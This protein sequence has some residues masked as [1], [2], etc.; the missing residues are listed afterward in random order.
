MRKTHLLGGCGRP[1]ASLGTAITCQQCARHFKVR[2]LADGR[3]NL[4]TKERKRQG[5]GPTTQR[6]VYVGASQYS[7]TVKAAD[8]A[9]RV[10]ESK[11]LRRKRIEDLLGQYGK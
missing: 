8:H 10:V 11:G 6:L 4:A 2:A 5:N 1:A 9:F 3:R 7:M